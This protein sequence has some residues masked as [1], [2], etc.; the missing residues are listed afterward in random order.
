MKVCL[1]FAS[2]LLTLQ[3][4]GQTVTGVVVNRRTS[5]PVDATVFLRTPD[6]RNHVAQTSTDSLGRF[7]FANVK[8]GSYMLLTG[9]PQDFNYVMDTSVDLRV[10]ANVSIAIAVD[11]PIES[12]KRPTGNGSFAAPGLENLPE[13]YHLEFYQGSSSSVIY[14]VTREESPMNKGGYYIK[15]VRHNDTGRVVAYYGLNTLL[16]YD[17]ATTFGPGGAMSIGAIHI[18]FTDELNGFL[19]GFGMV[20]TYYPFLYRT[21]DGGKTWTP[22]R[23][24]VGRTLGKHS[25]HFFD[26]QRGLLLADGYGYYTTTDGGVTW[27]QRALADTGKE[28]STFGLTPVYGSNGTVTLVNVDGRVFQSTDYGNN[29]KRLE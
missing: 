11:R 8:K 14:L 23:L 27:L 15:T 7:A 28:G 22:L 13:E 18:H 10:D 12:D 24:D 4:A 20:Y 19:Y 9:Y 16:F 1:L 26:S 25:L 29:F 2:L 17:T 6:N 5:V 21:S 3:L